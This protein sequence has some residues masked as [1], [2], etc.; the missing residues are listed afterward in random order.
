MTID[1]M[2]KEFNMYQKR[3]HMAPKSDQGGWGLCTSQDFQAK[4]QILDNSIL[5]PTKKFYCSHNIISVG[6]SDPCAETL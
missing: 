3:A 5:F 2:V 6:I 4:S 1:I